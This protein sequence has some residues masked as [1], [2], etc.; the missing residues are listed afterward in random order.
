[1]FITQSQWTK[2][3]VRVHLWQKTHKPAGLRLHGT[4]L[5]YKKGQALNLKIPELR[6]GK[7]ELEGAEER[8]AIVLLAAPADVK[9]RR[10]V[11]AKAWCAVNKAPG[12]TGLQGRH[13]PQCCSR[14][15]QTGCT[16]V[17][18]HMEMSCKSELLGQFFLSPHP[19]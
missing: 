11:A 3:K 5:L 10:M 18:H 9:V 17:G 8:K 15:A 7:G 14:G 16:H 4:T 19:Q 13:G 2:F 12:K 1:M 6:C